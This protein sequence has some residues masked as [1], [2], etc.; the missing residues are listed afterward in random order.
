MMCVGERRV[1]VLFKKVSLCNCSI[2][3]KPRFVPEHLDAADMLTR[4][5]AFCDYDRKQAN[6]HPLSA[7]AVTMI[8]NSVCCDKT[9]LTPKHLQNFQQVIRDVLEAIEEQ[10]CPGGSI[11]MPCYRVPQI[12]IVSPAAHV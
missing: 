8:E 9:F 7:A 6:I 5:L 2:G 10:R 11:S 12:P 1:R 4:R 3:P